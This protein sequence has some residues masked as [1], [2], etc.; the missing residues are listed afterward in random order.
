MN[1]YLKSDKSD[2]TVVL[3]GCSVGE[4]KAHLESLFTDGMSWENYGFYRVG[5]PRRWHIDHIL[6]CDSFDLTNPDQQKLCFHYTNLRPLWGD[7]NIS[8]SNKI[9]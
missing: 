4:F 7:L 8:K 1:R 2:H 6:P 5:E 3:L 9:G